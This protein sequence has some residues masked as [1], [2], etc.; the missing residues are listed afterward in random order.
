VVFAARVESAEPTGSWLVARLRHRGDGPVP[1]ALAAL[2]EDEE[3][4]RPGEAPGILVARLGP[5]ST[6][7]DRPVARV[8]MD[9]ERVLLFDAD[10]GAAL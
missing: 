3:G 7:R 4:A 2:R 1:P 9:C 8:W 10:T 6:A 5:A